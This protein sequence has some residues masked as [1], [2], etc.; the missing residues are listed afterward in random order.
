MVHHISRIVWGMERDDMI[1]IGGCNSSFT[2]I[3]SVV[4]EVSTRMRTEYYILPL[5]PIFQCTQKQTFWCDV[6]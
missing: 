5:L 3:T 4:T 6:G 2:N 1:K